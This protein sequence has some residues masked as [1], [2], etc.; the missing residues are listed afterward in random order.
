MGASCSPGRVTTCGPVLVSGSDPCEAVPCGSSSSASRPVLA[1]VSGAAA[2][3]EAMPYSMERHPELASS[4]ESVPIRVENF[5]ICRDRDTSG[6]RSMF[7]P[8]VRLGS[9]ISATVYEADELADNSV[10]RGVAVLGNA[11]PE[12]TTGFLR[13]CGGVGGA[14]RRVAVKVFKRVGT[15]SFKFELEAYSYLGIHPNITR[16]MQC[17]QNANAQDVLIYEC[18]DRQT[19]WGLFDKQCAQGSLLPMA[20]VVRIIHQ[21]LMALEHVAAC[22]IEHQDVKP[23]NI[24]LYRCSLADR[25]ADLKLG[26]FGWA[27]PGPW[28]ATR[29][30]P[31]KG[32]GSLWYAAPEMNPPLRPR[33][34]IS[35]GSTR[36]T[37]NS[38]AFGTLDRIASTFN[39]TPAP[40]QLV[41]RSDMWSAGVVLYLL[42]VGHN[43]FE[44]AGDL[45]AKEVEQELLRMVEE[46]N[47]DRQSRNWLMLA[48]DM[49]DFITNVLQVEP[50]SR[51][52][53]TEAISRIA[54]FS[55]LSKKAD[56]ATPQWI[57][58]QKERDEHWACLSGL[59]QMLWIAVARSV[60]EPEMLPEVVM[61]AQRA[62]RIGVSKPSAASVYETR[63]RQSYLHQLAHEL[64]ATP[65][66]GWLLEPAGFH[67]IARLAFSYLD[68]DAD[69]F[70]SPDDLAHHV[71]LP[72]SE[73]LRVAHHW[74]VAWR[75]NCE[76]ARG[77]APSSLALSPADVHAA[78]VDKIPGAGTAANGPVVLLHSAEDDAG[79]RGFARCGCSPQPTKAFVLPRA[80]CPTSRTSEPGA[81]AV[82]ESCSLLAW[83][84][85]PW[86]LSEV[87]SPLTP[88]SGEN[89][90]LQ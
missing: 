85:K 55:M 25:T 87:G 76:Q 1:A 29:E 86:P 73:A 26:D 70:L 2:V 47:F 36:C 80:G 17:F 89:Y 77:H 23:E 3:P 12:W 13:S 78:L 34:S 51:P 4:R 15:G 41:G 75:S 52:S 65:L 5:R 83:D 22:G 42:L 46:A 84:L 32:I 11:L 69:G 48:A 38:S 71:L 31:S 7:L 39:L 16:L 24:F 54:V 56:Q 66:S 20:L 45:P 28:C 14:G 6:W 27:T 72:P 64:S 18:C 37:S 19:L 59:Q 62:A 9:G 61:S 82:T 74:T 50:N 49:R 79:F 68:V 10:S 43:P 67:E 8:S 90:A 21:L 81:K 30:L 60:T 44:P 33:G 53:A 40:P 63:T 58:W 35:S 57:A 88:V